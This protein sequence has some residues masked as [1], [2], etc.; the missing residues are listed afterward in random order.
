MNQ[1]TQC[2]KNHFRK[3][4]MFCS[5]TCKTIYDNNKK[6]INLKDGYDFLTCPICKKKV[7]EFTIGHAK[8]HGYNT[9]REFLSD[10]GF[11]YA[12]CENKRE[13]V[14]GKN[15]PGY[16]HG[17]KLSPWSKNNPKNTSKKLKENYEKAEKSRK[18]KRS[19]EIGYWTSRGYTEDQ[20]KEEIS[21][22]QKTKSLEK[23]IEL[24][25]EEK[26]EERYHKFLKQLEEGRKDSAVNQYSKVSKE[27]FDGIAK[28]FPELRYG[29]NEFSIKCQKYN[30]HPSA[31]YHLDAFLESNRRAVEFYGDYWHLNPSKYNG[32]DVNPYNKELLVEDKWKHDKMRLERIKNQNVEVLV[33]WESD[34]YN[35]K[36]KVIKDIIDWLNYPQIENNKKPGPASIDDLFE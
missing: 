21:K 3:N 22:R 32:K 26:G 1:C 2:D 14:K 18:G 25:G 4:N 31:T 27:L 23:Q 11:K 5:Y 20:A 13:R 33:I 10:H 29:D 15:N 16:N 24:Y 19:N 34:Y 8:M 36:E 35:D 7:R 6:Y 30:N 9:V 28:I 12:V 17:G